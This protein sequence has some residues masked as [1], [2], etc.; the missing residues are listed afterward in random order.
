MP[1]R[2]T[3]MYTTI[4]ISDLNLLRRRYQ[5]QKPAHMLQDLHSSESYRHEPTLTVQE[6]I[7][8]HI[9]FQKELGLPGPTEKE[10]RNLGRRLNAHKYHKMFWK[11][12]EPG[13]EILPPEYAVRD[14]GCL[15]EL[16]HGFHR[17]SAYSSSV[18]Q[19]T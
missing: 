4:R 18:R 13:L 10:A 7:D 17:S 2:E 12:L 19:P 1:R 5:F 15:T 9:K 11:D 14:V 16:E 8:A 3:K 6:C